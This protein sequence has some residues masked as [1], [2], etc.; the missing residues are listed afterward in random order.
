MNKIVADRYELLTE[1]GRGGMSVV[2]L[3][4]DLSLNKNWAVKVV[5]RNGVYQGQQ[6]SNEIL[7]EA[8]IMKYLDHPNLP[9]IVDIIEDDSYLYIVMDYIEG[10]T[11]KSVLNSKGVMDQRKVVK[12]GKELASVLSYLHNQDP[13]IIYRDMKPGNIIL[14]PN[15]SLKLIDFGIARTYKGTN[16]KDTMSLGT[17]GYAAPEQFAGEDGSSHTDK[18]TDVYNLGVTLYE[19]LT[20]HVPS[21]PPYKLL[22]IR[23][24]NSTVSQGL[25][26]VITK[27]T[28]RDPDDRYQTIEELG[29]ALANYEKLDDEYI[30][31]QKRAIRKAVFPMI[32]GLVF[33]LISVGLFIF[34]MQTTA[35]NYE[36]LIMN[37]G[38]DK[39]TEENLL[40]AIDT[41]PSKPDAYELLLEHYSK[42]GLTES[43]VSIVLDKYNSNV[44]KLDDESFVEVSFAIGENILVYFTG[45]TD[46]S[47]RNKIIVSLP[48][49]EAITE[50]EN[51]DYENYDISRTYCE[52]GTFYKE[53]IIGNKGMFVKSAGEEEYEKLFK[54]FDAA[55]AAGNE[56]ITDQLKLTTCELMV[57]MLENERYSIAEHIS[58]SE[59]L[60]QTEKI[61]KVVDETEA[62]N[63]SIEE[64][65]AEIN[66]SIKTLQEHIKNTYENQGKKEVSNGNNQSGQ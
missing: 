20:D 65:K 33:M 2:Y 27:C 58:Q 62:N 40:K 6:V 32:T 37:T 28:Q 23:R 57:N 35:K 39:K 56:K 18:R 30:A 55:L 60:K 61:K 47:I 24:L 38:N 17:R 34:D 52:L 7:E 12:W 51:T 10:E 14:Q 8:N 1:V 54:T 13:P 44:G 36:S 42:D 9:R 48:F 46:S 3:A 50:T 19:L 64:Q 4:R 25:E 41:D 53:Y 59:F 49:F 31:S 43:E 22:P 11:L 63:T 45:E 29:Y 16:L 5:N 15:G 26:K 66:N 21:E